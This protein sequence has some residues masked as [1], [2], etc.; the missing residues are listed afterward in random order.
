MGTLKENN[1]LKFSGKHFGQNF[2]WG[3]VQ[4]KLQIWD[5]CIL[6][7]NHGTLYCLTNPIK[8]QQEIIC[9]GYSVKRKFLSDEFVQ[10]C[11]HTHATCGRLKV[12]HELLLL[13]IP[14]VGIVLFLFAMQNGV[15][16][17][18]TELLAYFWFS[19]DLWFSNRSSLLPKDLHFACHSWPL[20]Y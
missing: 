14:G 3:R 2:Y 16:I 19:H 11:K 9:F 6:R 12:D 8:H 4:E 15:P 20:I 1:W 5:E 17:R 7:S 18:W 13:Q 10:K